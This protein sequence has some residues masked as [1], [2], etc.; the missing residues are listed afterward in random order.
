MFIADDVGKFNLVVGKMKGCRSCT[1]QEPDLIMKSFAG[2][3]AARDRAVFAVGLYTGERITAILRLKVGDVVYADQIADSF[4][5][6]GQPIRAGK[7]RK[8]GRSS[9]I[10]GPSRR[11]GNGLMR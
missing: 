1:D 9:G 5:I 7:R 4:T 11:L 3:Y 10:P 8:A 6:A 2:T